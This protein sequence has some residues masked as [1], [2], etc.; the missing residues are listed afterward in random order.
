MEGSGC[1]E[2]SGAAYHFHR[3]CLGGEHPPGLMGTAGD[4]RHWPREHEDGGLDSLSFWVAGGAAKGPGLSGTGPQHHSCP[5]EAGG[6]GADTQM[7]WIEGPEGKLAPQVTCVTGPQ[8]VHGP[9]RQ[10]TLH[11]RLDGASVLFI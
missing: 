10:P 1:E 9:P 8:P 5:G 3:G 6:C 11:P 2:D 4:H 7:G